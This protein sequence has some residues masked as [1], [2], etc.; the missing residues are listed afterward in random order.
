MKTIYAR[1]LKT[2]YISSLWIIML[3]FSSFHFHLRAQTLSPVLSKTSFQP[4]YAYNITRWKYLPENRIHVQ[5]SLL[6][7]KVEQ[8]WLSVKMRL[9]SEQLEI[10]NYQATP[11]PF[12]WKGG[13]SLTLTLR[14]LLP[15]LEE[16]NMSISGNHREAFLR[17]GGMLP[18]GTYR[19][20]FEIF[21]TRSM[22]KVSIEEAPAII[23]LLSAQPPIINIPEDNL[24][25]YHTQEPIRFQWTPRHLGIA[26]YFQTEYTFELAEIPPGVNHWREYFHT[27]PVIHTEE[28]SSPWF[29]YNP[30]EHPLL[31][32]GCQYAFRVHARCYNAEGELLNIRNNGYSEVRRFYYEEICQEVPSLEITDISSTR[33]KVSWTVPPQVRSFKLQYRKNGKPTATWFT[34][35][36]E[37]THGSEVAWLENLEPATGYECRLIS[38]CDYSESKDN[39]IYRFT[40]LSKDNAQIECGKHPLGNGEMKDQTPLAQLRRFDHVKV[41]SGFIF[42]IEE[43]SGQ[44]GIFSGTANTRIPLLGNTGVQ[45]TFKNIFV[46]S[47]YELVSGTFQAC[48]DKDGL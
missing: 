29:S 8:A 10:T 43:V 25:F 45:V 39:R 1:T 36:E 48:T 12:P 40:T 23:H 38:R 24:T 4:P 5:V 3:L 46:N 34:H 47:N 19:L 18:D 17:S 9:E 42:E 15:C 2:F 21:E 30:Q 44:N 20:Y 31:I 22:Q 33:A 13:E 37:L 28:T 26:G 7:H 32:P 16:T 27:L 6:D 41:N 35:K 14:E 11:L